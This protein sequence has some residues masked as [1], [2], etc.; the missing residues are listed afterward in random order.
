[1]LSDG[2]GS[3]IPSTVIDLST[4]PF[5]ILREGAGANPF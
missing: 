4:S 3:N 2:F 1:M 5:E